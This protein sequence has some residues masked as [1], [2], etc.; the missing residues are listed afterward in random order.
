MATYGYTRVSTGEQALGTSLADQ[1]RKLEGLAMMRGE[2]LTDIATDAGVSGAVPFDQRPAGAALL[3]KLQPGDVVLVAKLDR[4]FRSAED[5]LSRARRWKEQHIGLVVADM[6]VDP[7][8][9]NGTSRM[10][11]GMLALVA[12]FERERIRERMADGRKAKAKQGGHIGGKRPFGYEVEGTGK[13]AR[14]VPLPEEQELIQR[15]LALRGQGASLR[16]ISAELEQEGHRLSH[17]GVKRL[18]ARH[19]HAE[20]A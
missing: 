8:T 17:V 7:V 13:E 9:D 6:G 5:A 10:F 18:L 20:A 3:A 2:E 19:G 4:I 12:E 14:L 15:I 16:A 1:R 11:F